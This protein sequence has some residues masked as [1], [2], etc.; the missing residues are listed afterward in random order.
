MISSINLEFFN[1]YSFQK[2]VILNF[3]SYLENLKD[4]SELIFVKTIHHE[5]K[6]YYELQPLI[7]NTIILQNNFIKEMK[8]LVKSYDEYFSDFSM[9]IHYNDKVIL[10]QNLTQ[11]KKEINFIISDIEISQNEEDNIHLHQYEDI[12][13]LLLSYINLVRAAFDNFD[14]ICNLSDTPSLY[15]PSLNF[16]ET[17]FKNLA[18]I[19][20]KKLKQIKP[21]SCLK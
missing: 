21:L 9:D 19:I 11:A 13:N 12:Y 4:A 16:Y 15:E 17:E 6:F 1:N 14:T 8:V 7:N 18:D 20:L 2:K 10:F 3:M 5:S